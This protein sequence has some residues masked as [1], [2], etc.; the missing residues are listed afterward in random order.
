MCREH[1][2]LWHAK[3][4]SEPPAGETAGAGG[5]EVLIESYAAGRDLD[6]RP[7]L[8]EA[9]AYVGQKIRAGD[10]ALKRAFDTGVVEPEAPKSAARVGGNEDHGTDHLDA[11]RNDGVL[12]L[13]DDDELA[14]IANRPEDAR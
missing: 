12:D 13:G 7:S 11:G 1:I 14:L 6:D 8:L 2:D 9:A 3:L 5:F 4:K 10:L